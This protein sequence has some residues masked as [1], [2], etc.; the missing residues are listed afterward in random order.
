MS[1]VFHQTIVHLLDNTLDI[2][3][4]SSGPLTLSDETEAFITSH[5]L[6][7]LENMSLSNGTFTEESDYGKLFRE[8][9][10]DFYE[11]SCD[12]ARQIFAYMKNYAGIPSGDLIIADFTR[13]TTHYFGF[14]KVNYKEAFTHYVDQGAEGACNTLIKHKSIFPD[15]SSK[16]QEA[17]LIDLSSLH[18]DVVD[19]LKEKYLKDLLGFTSSLTV[20]EKIKVVEHV[21]NEAIEENFENKLEAMSFVKNNI[22]KSI[23]SSSSIMLEEILEETFGDHEAIIDTCL[24]KCEAFGLT[25]KTIPLPKAETTYKKYASH[26]LK[27]N[28]GIELKLPT[29]MLNDPNIIEFINNPDGTISIVLKN[30][31]EL[32][33]K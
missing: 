3:L 15:S 12:L 25:E 28:T 29:E 7:L 18:L 1:I 8:G 14:F 23:S 6:K 31:A 13:D 26:K 16:I 10:Y 5:M 21:M 9:S 17:V 11:L 27:T 24:S 4:L 20:K 33:N 2:P 19:T 22:A 30:I 32:I